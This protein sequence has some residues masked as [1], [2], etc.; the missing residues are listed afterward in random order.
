MP[1]PEV[2]LSQGTFLHT[3]TTTF[4]S[5][6]VDAGFD[7]V[8]VWRH[9]PGYRGA[10]ATFTQV[11]AAGTRVASVCTG[12]YLLGDVDHLRRAIDDAAALGA[13]Q[14][15]V[16]TGPRPGTTSELETALDRLLPHAEQAGVVLAL[17][18]FHPM[19][20]AE[21]S[22]LVTL[23]QAAQVLARFDT[24]FLGLAADCYHLWWDP[25]LD[26][27]LR[28]VGERI[29]AV[30]IADW[31]SPNPDFLRGRGLPGEGVIPI[32]HFLELVAEA[33]Y[34]GPIEV[35]VLNDR[36]AEMPPA[37][38]ARTLKTSLERTLSA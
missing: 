24:P 1:G 8:T 5:A 27:E 37:L 10:G 20:A 13:P 26:R 16:V 3:D 22:W 23:D 12:G 17:E 32:G 4:L 25:N 33:G 7:A 36:F 30:H 11:E 34:A 19:F 38:A 21:R 15:V 14:L 2:V 6:A 28:R 35:E 31:V 18:P 9:A 29:V